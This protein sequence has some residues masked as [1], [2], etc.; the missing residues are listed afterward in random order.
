MKLEI[1][2][3]EI[4]K[5]FPEII[6]G[7]ST[8]IGLNRK[9]PFFFNLSL[10]VADDK[11][12]VKENRR[13]F[14]HELGLKEENVAIQKQTHSTNITVV[15]KGGIYPDSDAL[16][17]ETP[18]IGLAISSAD[19]TPVFIYDPVKKIVCGIHSGWKGTELQIVANTLLKLKEEFKCGPNDLFAYIGP[20]ISCDNYEVGKE[21]ADKFPEQFVKHKNNKIYLD[22]A[23]VNYKMLVDA[24]IPE[25]QIEKSPLCS[26]QEKDLLHSYRRDGLHSGRALGIIAMKNI[27]HGK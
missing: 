7:F 24:G 27:N 17:T 21:V 25:N 19:C 13:S 15:N 10:T 22:V 5:Q 18:G 14:Y 3:S 6:F 4:F 11:E 20:S 26:Y 9:A 12:I 2:R 8:K 16:I 1:I 23:G